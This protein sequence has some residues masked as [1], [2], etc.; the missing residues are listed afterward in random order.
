MGGAV[1]GGDGGAGGWVQGAVRRERDGERRDKGRE[2]EESV[3]TRKGTLNKKGRCMMFVTCS[4]TFHDE[5]K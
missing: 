2:G 4:R 1:G 3:M 5:R